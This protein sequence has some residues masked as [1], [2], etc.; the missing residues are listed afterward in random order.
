MTDKE[1]GRV[2][3]CPAHSWYREQAKGRGAQRHTPDPVWGGKLS[4][5][6]ERTVCREKPA[7][8]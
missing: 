3:L 8:R 6:W 1:A 5:V 2:F 7:Q 4:Q